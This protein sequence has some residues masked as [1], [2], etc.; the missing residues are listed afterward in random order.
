MIETILVIICSIISSILYRAGGLGLSEPYWIPAWMRHSWVRDWLC[1]FFCLLPLF[2]QYPSW[3]FILAYGAMGGAFSTYF[4]YKGEANFGLS[5][6]M[7][8]LAALPLIWVGFVWWHLLI[9]ALFIGVAWFVWSVFIDNDHWE[10]HGR[11]FFA[12]IANLFV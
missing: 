1:P 12:S 6:F 10:E 9:R 5:G 4:K 11:G 7:V 3:L 8:G 2:L